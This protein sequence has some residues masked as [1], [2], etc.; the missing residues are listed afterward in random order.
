M[1]HGGVAR[2]LTVTFSLSARCVEDAT[3]RFH[4]SDVV[5]CLSPH[6][7]ADLS[8]STVRRMRLPSR[9]GVFAMVRTSLSADE[10]VEGDRQIDDVAIIWRSDHGTN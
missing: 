3:T 10:A 2:P 4:W 1:G 8:R 6:V 5:N 7:A 9:T